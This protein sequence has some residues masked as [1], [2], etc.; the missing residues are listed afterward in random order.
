MHASSGEANRNGCK[1]GQ[2]W[3]S[4]IDSAGGIP[5]GFGNSSAPLCWQF[6]RRVSRSR[7]QEPR[8][9]KAAAALDSRLSHRDNGEP[10]LG[11]RPGRGRDVTALPGDTALCS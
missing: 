9:A 10:L 6:G 4:Q 5:A 1:S 11:T 3:N 8:G 7:V 2:S